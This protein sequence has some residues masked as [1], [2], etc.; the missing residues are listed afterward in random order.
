M[1]TEIIKVE[2]LEAAFDGKRILKG[3][4]FTAY[5]NEITVILGTS[6]LFHRTLILLLV[7]SLPI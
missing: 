2:N 5:Q 4:S 7:F 6:R 3:V 1:K